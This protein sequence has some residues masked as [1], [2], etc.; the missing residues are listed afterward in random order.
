VTDLSVAS[1]LNFEVLLIKCVCTSWI[2]EGLWHFT[3]GC[4]WW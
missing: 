2:L 4:W 3:A 1:K